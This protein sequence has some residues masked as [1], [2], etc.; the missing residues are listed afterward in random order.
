VAEPIRELVMQ[1]I[2]TLLAAIKADEGDTYSQTVV[3]VSR[4][5]YSVAKN[6]P[7]PS[8][9]IFEV[10]EEKNTENADRVGSAQCRLP[11]VV[12][13]VADEEGDVGTGTT[14][15][16]M[17]ADLTRAL[18]TDWD[19]V[20]AYGGIDRVQVNESSNSTSEGTESGM[21]WVQSLF[22]FTYR[23]T[24]GDQTRIYEA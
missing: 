15:N 9:W 12:T 5:V 14:K 16:R 11:V 1:K 6:P 21:V 7:R 22:T 10:D 2:E 20:D 4:D 23:H 24:L 17:L 13:Y 19:I 18:G 8:V 3:S